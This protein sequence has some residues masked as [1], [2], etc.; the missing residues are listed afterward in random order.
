MTIL[1]SWEITHNWENFQTEKRVISIYLCVV[2]FSKP[3]RLLSLYQGWNRLGKEKLIFVFINSFVNNCLILHKLV[4]FIC[5][6]LFVNYV[7]VYGK[8]TSYNLKRKVIFIFDLLENA[9]W[10]T[11]MGFVLIKKT[12]FMRVYTMNINVSWL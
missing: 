1:V 9:I 5:W 8:Q 7:C 2:L 10:R 4:K 6:K 12:E 11:L 3:T